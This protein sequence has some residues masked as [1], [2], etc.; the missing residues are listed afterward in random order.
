MRLRL[1]AAAATVLS[2]ALAGCGGASSTAGNDKPAAGSKGTVKIAINPWVGYE[3]NAAVI[4][5]VL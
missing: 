1:P 4:A 5:H 2:L 3:A